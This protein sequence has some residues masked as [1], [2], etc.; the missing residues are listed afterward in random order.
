MSLNRY[1]SF[2]YLIDNIN[3]EGQIIDNQYE[4]TVIQNSNLRKSKQFYY[5]IE[6]QEI[7]KFINIKDFKTFT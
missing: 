4:N 1:N 7:L 5:K 6:D 2:K 3:K